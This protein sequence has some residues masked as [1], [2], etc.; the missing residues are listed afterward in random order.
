MPAVPLALPAEFLQ[1]ELTANAEYHRR[2]GERRTA[3]NGS[4]ISSSVDDDEDATES[5]ARA[6]GANRLSWDEEALDTSSSQD[7]EDE[8][9]EEGSDESEEDLD[10][11][12]LLFPVITASPGRPQIEASAPRRRSRS[13]SRS[14]LS[15]SVSWHITVPE[16]DD[17]VDDPEDPREANPSRDRTS[18]LR[19]DSHLFDATH[20]TIS[21][22]QD[23][24]LTQRTRPSQKSR[25]IIIYAAIF[26]V[27]YVVSL[28]SNTGYLY[29]NFA[30]SEFGALAS[31]STVAICQQM[32]FA[33]AKPPIAKLSDVFGRAEALVFSIALYASGY[34]IVATAQSLQG[35]IGG[36]VLQSAGNTGVLV[37][38]SIIIA[39]LTTAQWRGLVIA[40]VNL[41]YLI[42]FAVAGPL[43]DAVMGQ[44]GWRF[45]YGMWSIVVPLAATPLIVILA[46]GQHQARKVG[47]MKRKSVFGRGLK[48]SL[49]R[50]GKEIDAAGLIIFT[51]AWLFLLGPLTLAGHGGNAANSLPGSLSVI[52]VFFGAMLLIAFVFWESRASNPILPLRFLK[53]RAVVCVCVIGILD[54][55]S[56]YLSW[57]F[58]S[59]FVSIVDMSATGK[60]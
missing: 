55:A 26:A 21:S 13:H 7:E 24:H 36:I 11:P 1:T 37:L 60:V 43:V 22:H 4:G 41:P 3:Q 46:I 39:D 8:E 50:L 59:A 5:T 31:F 53:N 38:Q 44:Y 10:E 27:A 23:D 2:E 20:S 25:I 42:N 16:D 40:L 58:L 29:L 17:D 6:A 30:C 52:L 54:F 56:F 18:F 32:V 19:P 28:D 9:G 47:L 45:G 57:T 51:L 48:T 12:P 49:Y 14:R 34:G 35:V 33:I 15:R